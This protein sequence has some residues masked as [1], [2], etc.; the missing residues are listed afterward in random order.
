MSI[1][2]IAAQAKLSKIRYIQRIVVELEHFRAE[3][4]S[5]KEAKMAQNLAERELLTLLNIVEGQITNELEVSAIRPIEGEMGE[6]AVD[7]WPTPCRI[8][9]HNHAEGGWCYICTKNSTSS[10]CAHDAGG[11]NDGQSIFKT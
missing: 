8:C 2:Y 7:P 5:L 1:T 10:L 6:G 4:S 9:K 3:M 11:T